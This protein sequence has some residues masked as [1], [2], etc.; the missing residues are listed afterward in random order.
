MTTR[1]P[2]F[3]EPLFVSRPIL[4]PLEEYVGDLEEIWRSQYLTNMGPFHS[5]LE[6]AL[7]ERVEPSKHGQEGLSSMRPS[8]S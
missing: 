3:T 5:R 7:Q 6:A 2:R 4:P 8:Q 1:P